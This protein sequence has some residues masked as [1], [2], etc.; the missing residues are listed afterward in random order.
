MLPEALKAWGA[1]KLCFE[2][3]SEPYAQARDAAATQAAQAAG[4]EVVSC[5]SHTIYDPRAVLRANKGKPTFAYQAR[6][7]PAHGPCS[8]RDSSCAGVLQAGGEAA[9][10]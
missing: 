10:A 4:C 2:W 6:A 5:V 1:K 7:G 3:D 9:S 8:R